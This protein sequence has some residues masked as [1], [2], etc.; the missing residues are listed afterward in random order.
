MTA[1]GSP[2]R[3]LRP[4]QAARPVRPGQAARPVRPGQAAHPVPVAKGLSGGGWREDGLVR[5]LGGR[6]LTD[7]LGRRLELHGVNLVAK[8]GGGA[9]PINVPGTPCVGPAQGPKLA[10][11]LAPRA[12]DPARRFTA[13]D[14]RT[15][16][17]LGFNVVRLGIVWEGLEPGP[18]NVQAD[19]PRYCAPHYGPRFPSLGSADP[20]SAATVRAYLQRTDRIVHLLA[21]ANIRVILDMHQDVWGSAFQYP[22][23][24]TPWSGE[25]APMWAT[26]TEGLSFAA[27]VGWGSGYD[28]PAV[29]ASIHH[30]WA[31]NVRGDLQG[32]FARVWTAV[33]KHFAGD[34]DVL[35]Y[36]VINEPNDFLVTSF[37]PELQCAYGGRRH[38]P[39]SCAI[40]HAAPVPNGLIGTIQTADPDHVVVYE[41][42]GG[43]DFGAPE[44]IGI[45][46]PLRFKDLALGFHVYGD[47]PA[48]LRQTA[49]ERFH[50]R[51]RQPGGPP[52]IMDEFGASNNYPATAATVALADASNLSWVYWAALQLDDPTAGDAYE[53]LLDQVT[54]KPYWP[55]AA[56]LSAPYPWAT[57][58]TPGPQSFNPATG[59]FRYAYRVIAKITA[60]TE[61]ML[62]RYVY[63]RGYAVQVRGAKVV[64]R[65]RA[66]VLELKARKGVQWVRIIV[67]RR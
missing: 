27:P 5:A 39:R 67:R 40:S 14:A 12:R 65:R 9:Q 60:P 24:F 3:P 42:S 55:L 61:I 47:I 2:S 13:A 66:T 57:A 23:G 21:R 22:L 11:V 58:G 16:A 26:C 15:L 33:A 6:Y 36:E 32:Q 30:F 56:A 63:P 34:P 41:P 10:Y 18:A 52:A 1:A 62:P 54:R 50:T 8:C 46:E 59:M 20:Y 4:G 38:E 53:G 49:Q 29:Q 25:G 64:S 43:A 31:N 37:D 28:A 44:T 35:G 17:W 51:T 48:Q 19:D 7:G 45:A